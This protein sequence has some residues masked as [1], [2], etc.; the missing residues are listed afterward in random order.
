MKIQNR[1]AKWVAGFLICLSFL[2]TIDFFIEFSLDGIVF[3]SVILMVYVVMYLITTYKQQALKLLGITFALITVIYIAD[4][5]LSLFW[6][7]QGDVVLENENM[8]NESSQETSKKDNDSTV[9]KTSNASSSTSSV[10]M[11]HN[12][13]WLQCLRDAIDYKNITHF[14]KWAIEER[15]EKQILGGEKIALIKKNE[16]AFLMLLAVIITCIVG[17]ILA[18]KWLNWMLILPLIGYVLL[19]YFY[20]DIPLLQSGFYFT[21]VLS[22]LIFDHSE[23]V[24]NRYVGYNTSYYKS[25]RV[26]RIALLGSIFIVVVASAIS[27]ILPVK[28][29]NYVVDLIT[30]NIWGTRS[31]Y[32]SSQFKMY[33]LNE[34]PY[35][36]TNDIL[37]GPVEPINMVDPIFWVKFDRPVEQA[38]YLKTS[39]KDFY[40]G[41]KWMN[42]GVIYKNGF[43]YYLS[44]E[45]NQ[46]ILKSG[47]FDGIGGTIKIN[48]KEAKTTTLF[49][50]MGLFS[51]SLGDDKIYVSA[52]NEAFYKAG[53]FVK[54]LKQ[55]DF[56]AS[57]CD[58]FIS[59]DVDYLQLSD[60]IE[61]KTIEL[62]KELGSFGKTDIEKVEIITSF[63]SQNYE[64]TLTPL[65]NYSRR[66]FGS[67]FLF[68]GK[69]G[70]CTYFASALV[71]LARSN[72]IPARYVEGFR[73]D[74]V[75]VDL[76]G[77][78]SKVTERDA[79]A[80]AEVYLK[81]YGWVIFESTP[82]YS[83]EQAAVKAPTLAML[84][85]EKNND[86]A[87]NIEP[88][89]EKTTYGPVDVAGLLMEND[90]GINK[91]SGDIKVGKP[92]N[93]TFQIIWI[94]Y[95][96]GGLTVCLC[97]W[98]VTRL[99]LG[100][101]KKQK[102][103][104]YAVRSIYYLTYLIAEAKNMQGYNPE[105]VLDKGNYLP[106]E[107]KLW[108]KILYAPVKT[109]NLNDINRSIELSTRYLKVAK[110]N[111]RL[112]KG[113]IAYIKMRLFKI[114]KLIP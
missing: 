73:V 97:I 99:P 27:I 25:G 87:V 2:M 34:T 70:Y 104:K 92:H 108:Y 68:E 76:E 51:T 24:L 81:D 11:R 10:T 13:K 30:P 98:G 26:M 114:H 96:V 80:W 7:N 100:Y 32:E 37:G 79:H 112:H 64:Y 102:T 4:F 94:F 52:E 54:Y 36:G 3:N 89:A 41:L 56:T 86:T 53:V 66:D 38:I 91:S 82:S 84:T 110:E 6:G 8:K 28:Q 19:W 83:D 35:K 103:H 58:F 57:Q 47:N 15:I 63:L 16:L 17:V 44:N 43:K 62:G 77:G 55:Y 105:I 22:F 60:R 49:T 14:G 50:P 33:S 74:P 111:Y 69:R 101:M 88:S 31:G 18:V 23:R 65:S 40:D 75:E 20:V 61:K 9:N 29:I 72:D 109:V 21:G 1:R 113:R 93:K 71:I 39:I 46:E 12:V 106:D 45:N 78:F 85:D 5:S 95:A 59:P 90:G 67:R 42:N 48:S 107:K